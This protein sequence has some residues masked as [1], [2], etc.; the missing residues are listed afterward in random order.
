VEEVLYDPSRIEKIYATGGEAS[1]RHIRQYLRPGLDLVAADPKLSATFIGRDALQTDDQ[2]RDVAERLALDVGIFNQEACVNARLVYV[3]CG[4]DDAGATVLRRLGQL[5]YEAITALPPELSAP[6]EHFDPELRDALDSIRLADD[7]YEVI[8]ATGNEGAVVLS[9]L[10]DQVDFSHLLTGR[11]VNL[12]PVDAIDDALRFVTAYT[13]TVGVY[14]PDLKAVL[15]DRMA[16]SG[17]Q[18]I[19]TLGHATDT[20][21]ATPVDGMEPLRRLC[22]WIVD[23]DF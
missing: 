13:Q 5:I 23:E 15:R 21:Y 16:L 20:S 4:T 14:P 17:A 3:E 9:F 11:V 22:K 12:I 10:G 8:G 6:V 1:M 18:R 19:V 2:L 7:W